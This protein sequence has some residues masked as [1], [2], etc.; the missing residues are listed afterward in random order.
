MRKTVA[1]LLLVFVASSLSGCFSFVD[2]THNLN[3]FRAWGEDLDR[4]HRSVDRIFLN[5]D[6]D[7]PSRDILYE[8]PN[9]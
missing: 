2:W 9:T 5:Y 4:A 1:V 8:A 7:D 3:H 6:Y